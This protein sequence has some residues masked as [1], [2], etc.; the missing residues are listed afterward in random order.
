MTA[1]EKSE[2]SCSL[3]FTYALELHPWMG[4]KPLPEEMERREGLRGVAS[5]EVEAEAEFGL[6]DI[7]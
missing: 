6:Q 4:P 5:L 2:P 7:S 1:P 3:S